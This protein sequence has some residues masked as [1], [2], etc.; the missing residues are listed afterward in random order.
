MHDNFVVAC[1]GKVAK[2]ITHVPARL[3]H[4][5]LDTKSVTLALWNEGKNIYEIAKERKLV[6]QTIFN[7]V[8]ELVKSNHIT[9]DSLARIVSPKIE[10]SMPEIHKAFHSLGAEKLAPIREH[11]NKKYS[12]D[13]LRIARMFLKK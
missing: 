10:T 6:A 1:G 12:Y 9:L 3:P 4:K 5:K 8:E 2:D 7:H 11:L 13:D